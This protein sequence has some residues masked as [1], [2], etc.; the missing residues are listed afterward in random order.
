VIVTVED[1]GNLQDKTVAPLRRAVA[2]GVEVKAKEAE[3]K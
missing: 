3:K 1:G 2:L